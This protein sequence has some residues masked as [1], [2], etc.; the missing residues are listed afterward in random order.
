V[1]RICSSPQ[2]ILIHATTHSYRLPIEECKTLTDH[3]CRALVPSSQGTKK[4]ILENTCRFP[5]T[6][7]RQKCLSKYKIEKKVFDQL[8]HRMT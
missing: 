2:D 4:R 1:V 6:R 5:F 8:S 3:N 7:V